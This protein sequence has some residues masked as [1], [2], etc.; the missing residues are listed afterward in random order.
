MEI[1]VRYYSRCLLQV[2]DTGVHFQKS[3]LSDLIWLGTK[4]D[5]VARLETTKNF[6]PLPLTREVYLWQVYMWAFNLENITVI[7]S[8]PL[9]PT[10][11]KNDDDDDDGLITLS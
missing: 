6:S 5:F 3:P 1:Q 10:P 9:P 7:P 4:D 11:S 2:F 8:H